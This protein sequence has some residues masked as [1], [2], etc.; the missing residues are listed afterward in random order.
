MCKSNDFLAKETLFRPCEIEVRAQRVTQYGVQVLLYQ[1][2]RDAMV[3]LDMVYG[4]FGWRD[5]YETIDKHTVI[6]KDGKEELVGKTV[7]KLSV[8]NPETGEWVTKWDVGT[9]S[10]MEAEKG[11]FSDCLKRASVKVL[12]APRALYTAP[13][14]F[15]P[16]AKCNIKSKGN[17]YACYDNFAVKSIE[18][19]DY[20]H[21][22]ALEIINE[23]TG[24]VVFTWKARTSAAPQAPAPATAPQIA[25]IRDMAETSAVPIEYIVKA[26]G[27]EKLADLTEKKAAQLITNFSKC[28]AAYAR[29]LDEEKT[30]EKTETTVEDDD[31]IELPYC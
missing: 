13:D 20:D 21:I 6:N 5:E 8:R 31:D 22:S 30:A 16:A 10:N 4:V 27:V 12:R 24:S 19:D 26:Y 17:G 11:L 1:T 28:V 2:A 14:I 3:H 9:E 25:A 18:Y 7:C 23:K 29:S 15:I